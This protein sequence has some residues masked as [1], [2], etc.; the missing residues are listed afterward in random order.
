MSEIVQ[1]PQDYEDIEPSRK[2]VN[3][4]SNIVDDTF[5]ISGDVWS[6]GGAMHRLTGTVKE[7]TLPMSFSS[8]PYGNVLGTGIVSGSTIQ[9]MSYLNQG[10]FIDLD[11]RKLEDKL[12][13]KIFDE[14]KKIKPKVLE[15]MMKIANKFRDFINLFVVEDIVVTGSMANYN[16]TDKSDIDLH[17]VYDFSSIGVDKDI[18]SDLFNC[19]KQLFN[20]TYS[21]SINGIPVEVGVED[22]NTPLA[23]T[24][25]FSL[26]KNDWVIEP[27]KPSV[28]VPDADTNNVSGWC[29]KIEK[30]IESKDLDILL[31]TWKEIKNMRK[32]SLKDGGEFSQGNLIFKELRDSGQ[33]RRLK[34]ALDDAISKDLSMNEMFVN[35]NKYPKT[36]IPTCS[37]IWSLE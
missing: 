21:I 23:S 33:I 13:D 34:N 14:N 24:G 19:K 20:N 5:K 7:G 27:Q 31:G 36:T 12:C 37:Y 22:S 4:G 11:E 35:K 26:L 32:S 2:F 29:E 8:G 1:I 18:L 17:L 3:D 10:G 28:E 25:V 9:P 30:A 6:Q 15:S 16:Y